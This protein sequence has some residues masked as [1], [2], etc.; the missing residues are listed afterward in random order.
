MDWDQ[1]TMPLNTGRA[2]M[3]PRQAAQAAKTTGTPKSQRHTVL[4]L[5]IASFK[6]S[7]R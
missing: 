7:K 1:E 6:L 3:I 4:D 2:L 5:E